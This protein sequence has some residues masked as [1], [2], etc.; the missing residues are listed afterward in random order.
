MKK[1]ARRF[2]FKFCL[3][4][5][6]V[7]VLLLISRSCFWRGGYT[8]SEMQMRQDQSERQLRIISK[9]I[10]HYKDMHCGKLPTSLSELMGEEMNHGQLWVFHA[11]I[12][13]T[14]RHLVGSMTNNLSFN[15]NSDYA[16]AT[17]I[18]PKRIVIS[19]NL[20]SYVVAYEKPGLWADE[21]VAVYFKDVGS[22]RLRNADAKELLEGKGRKIKYV[23]KSR[24]WTL[25]E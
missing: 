5:L 10:L 24:L 14:S 15:I 13:G 23:R 3:I 9:W 17:N 12:K 20:E 1:R 2:A 25:A 21:T 19:T 7:V 16:I 8:R 18:E 4:N 22:L 11:P 6:L